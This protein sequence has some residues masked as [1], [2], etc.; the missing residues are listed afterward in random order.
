MPAA[1]LAGEHRADLDPVDAGVLDDPHLVLGDLLVG[2]HQ[3][4]AG[5][6]I[7]DVL[8]GHAAEDAIP[9]L[10]DDLAALDQRGDLDALQGAAVVLGDD[11]VLGHVDQTPGEVPELAVL[12]AVSARPLRAPWVEMKYWRTESPS[13]K[14]VVMGRLDDLARGLG[15]QAAHAGQLA[16]SAGPNRGRPSRP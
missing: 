2:L 15:H 6:G 11:A 16:G 9:E 12:S 7:E 10:L 1:G 14:L 3:H 5:V 13:R 4:L 8:D